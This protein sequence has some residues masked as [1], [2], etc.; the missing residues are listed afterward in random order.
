[1]YTESLGSSLMGTLDKAIV[2]RKALVALNVPW[3]SYALKAT[4]N[5]EAASPELTSL[6]IKLVVVDEESPD[7]L[8]WLHA[9]DSESFSGT[10]ARGAGSLF[11]LEDG[12]VVDSVVDGG[13]LSFQE[14]LDRTRLRWGK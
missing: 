13:N 10:F 3:S 8:A 2:S 7:V 12:H 5:L 1:M 11:W 6:E 14:L 9:Q 4:A